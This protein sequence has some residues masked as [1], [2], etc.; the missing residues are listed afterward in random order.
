MSV[1][2]PIPLS[3]ERGASLSPR[4]P[5]PPSHSAPHPPGAFQRILH[6]VGAEVDR[7]ERMIQGV[8]S[9]RAGSLGAAE[10]IA[11]QAGIYRYTELVD[12]TSKFVDRAANAVR[13][14][15]QSSG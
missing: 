7:G 6:S 1:E 8:V 9:G 15:L 10:L 2:F 3:P 4:P 12:L 14:T 11:L 5:V 13:T